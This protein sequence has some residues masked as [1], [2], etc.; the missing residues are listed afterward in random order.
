M[1]SFLILIGFQ[2]LIFTQ[3]KNGRFISDTKIG[4]GKTREKGGYSRG[5]GIS[6]QETET[7]FETKTKF[8][9]STCTESSL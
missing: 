4:N 9:F 7:N 2:K 1:V 6:I 8:K 3:Q 5:G